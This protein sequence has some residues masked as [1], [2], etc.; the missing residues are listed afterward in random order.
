MAYLCYLCNMIL[1]VLLNVYIAKKEC[2]KL[3]I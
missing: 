2:F 3:M 1:E